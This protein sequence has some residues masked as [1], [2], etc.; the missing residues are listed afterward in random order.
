LDSQIESLVVVVKRHRQLLVAAALGVAALFY[1]SL[2]SYVQLSVVAPLQR[3]LALGLLPSQLSCAVALG[4]VSGLSAPGLT[5]PSLAA[6]AY[7]AAAVGFHCDASVMAIA[8][9]LNVALTVPDLLLWNN[10][11]SKLGA[12]VLPGGKYVRPFVAGAIPWALSAPPLFLT[13]YTVTLPV[14]KIFL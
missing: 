9:A 12:A 6:C 14:A 13:V 8:A 7:L 11:Y 2:L 3:T 4:L 10:F 1:S 5:M